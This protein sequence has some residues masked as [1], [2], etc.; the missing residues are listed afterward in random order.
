MAAVSEP[1]GEQK[2]FFFVKENCKLVGE[3]ESDETYS[4]LG[5]AE[6]AAARVYKSDR[7]GQTAALR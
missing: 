4:E 3:R 7:S 5:F 6:V 2:R 1:V